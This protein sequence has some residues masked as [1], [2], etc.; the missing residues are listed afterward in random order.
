MT[1]RYPF[2]AVQFVTELIWELLSQDAI[3]CWPLA[4]VVPLSVELSLNIVA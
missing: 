2:G 4:W 3:R 1:L